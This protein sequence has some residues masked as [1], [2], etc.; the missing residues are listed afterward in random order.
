[1]KKGLRI[2]VMIVMILSMTACIGDKSRV[3]ETVKSIQT[4]R[5]ESYF[6]EDASDVSRIFACVFKTIIPEAT[7]SDAIGKMKWEVERVTNDKNFYITVSYKNATIKFLAVLNG[8]M[9]TIPNLDEA[10]VYYDGDTATLQQL[11]L[12]M[13]IFGN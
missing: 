9:V 1:M 4:D 6:K 13:T 12:A 11:V 3:I 8:D 2:L 7:W 10:V 5:Y